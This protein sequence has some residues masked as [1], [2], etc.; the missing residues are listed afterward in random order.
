MKNLLSAN[1][2]CELLN[3]AKSSVYSFHQSGRLKGIKIG[4]LVRFNPDEVEEFINKERK[5]AVKQDD[6]SDKKI[7]KTI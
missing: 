3:C 7:Q 2:V 1:D 6:E 5:K 4:K